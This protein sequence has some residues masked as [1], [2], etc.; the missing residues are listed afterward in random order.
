MLENVYD[1]DQGFVHNDCVISGH[2]CLIQLQIMQ[3]VIQQM[4]WHFN[5]V[6]G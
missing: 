1:V 3:D 5:I 2:L 4:L 6:L